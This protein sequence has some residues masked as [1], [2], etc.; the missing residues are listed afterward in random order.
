[1]RFQAK[2]D[3]DAGTQ[4]L[5]ELPVPWEFTALTANASRYKCLEM[6]EKRG[7]SL[8]RLSSQLCAARAE[9]ES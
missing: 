3:G 1:M 2:A 7:I 9:R 8:L 4:L 5:E 6:P